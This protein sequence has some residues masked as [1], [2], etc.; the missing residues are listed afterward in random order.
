VSKARRPTKN[1]TKKIARARAFTWG[2]YLCALESVVKAMALAEWCAA[3]LLDPAEHK[4]V[5]ALQQHLVSQEIAAWTQYENE[6]KR[7]GR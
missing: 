4:A 5:L 3:R 1:P 7:H 2:R 6:K